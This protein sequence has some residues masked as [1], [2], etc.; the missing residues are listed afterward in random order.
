MTAQ[1]MYRNDIRADRTSSGSVVAE[2][3][4]ASGEEA[5]ALTADA[6]GGPLAAV[7]AGCGLGRRSLADAAANH[8]LAADIARSFTT[9]VR[10][11]A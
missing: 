5:A 3:H 1:L 6:L 4:P 2:H 9:L 7:A 10:Q 11:A 8:R